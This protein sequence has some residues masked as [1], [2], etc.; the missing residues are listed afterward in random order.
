MYSPTLP[1]QQMLRAIA[2]GAIA[3][4]LLRGNAHAEFRHYHIDAWSSHALRPR[5]ARRVSLVV[6][7]D[8]EEVERSSSL[9]FAEAL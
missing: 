2:Q 6:H 7:F 9:L 1:E 4:A 5:G 8:G 3:E